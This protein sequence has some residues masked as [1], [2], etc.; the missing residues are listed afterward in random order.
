MPRYHTDHQ[1]PIMPYA[2]PCV[3]RPHQ[4][5]HHRF[6]L[7]FFESHALLPSTIP[8]NLR[9]MFAATGNPPS[10]S[11]ELLFVPTVKHLP[12]RNCGVDGPG[13]AALSLGRR[14]RR[15]R[16]DLAPSGRNLH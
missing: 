11:A 8:A 12:N 13:L 4:M 14:D 16:L 9:L 15:P 10:Q 5:S 7:E 6:L 2:L 1:P 3:E